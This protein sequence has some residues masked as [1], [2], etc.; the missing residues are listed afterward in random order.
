[1]TLCPVDLQHHNH[2][3]RK[4]QQGGPNTGPVPAR[5]AVID[6]ARDLRPRVLR[7]LRE[8]S[9]G[10]F[11]HQPHSR[12]RHRTIFDSRTDLHLRPGKI[13]R[14]RRLRGDALMK[15]R[16]MAQPSAAWVR[17]IATH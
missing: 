7:K 12:K 17:T 9:M 4:E 5:V 11:R 6:L 16:H 10:L 8:R 15:E 2:Q 13:A 3:H 1:M 14:S